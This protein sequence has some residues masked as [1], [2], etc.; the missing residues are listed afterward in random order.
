MALLQELRELVAAYLRGEQTIDALWLWI[1]GHVQSVGDAQNED[2]SLLDG[3]LWNLLVDEGDGWISEAEVCATLADLINP[4]PIRGVPFTM[5]VDTDSPSVGHL[6]LP[7]RLKTDMVSRY[8]H[9][10]L[11]LTA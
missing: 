11:L 8:Q 4:A 10:E 2:L 6:N 7:A 5:V 9:K 1:T 3:T